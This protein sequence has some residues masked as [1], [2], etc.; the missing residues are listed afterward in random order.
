[1][2]SVRPE[3]EQHAD[4]LSRASGS[5]CVPGLMACFWTLVMLMCS[6]IVSAQPSNLDV[7]PLSSSKEAWLVTYGP[8]EIYWQ[9]FGH[10][11]IWIRDEENGIDHTFNFGFFDFEQERFIAR[12]IQGKMLYFAVAQVAEKEFEQ[13]QSENRSV[14]AQKLNLPDGAFEELRNY[15]VQQVQAE[16]RDY[17]YDYYLNNCSTRVRDALDMALGGVLQERTSGEA[18]SLNFR[19]H[20]RRSTV[21]DF[22]YYLAL[23]TALG[24]PVDRDI[25]RWEEMFLPELVSE[26]ISNLA[27]DGVAAA[28]PKLTIFQADTVQ[29]VD[30]VSSSWLR[31]LSV[32]ILITAFM[33]VLCRITGPIMSAGSVLAW[34]LIAASGGLVLTGL[35][36]FTDHAVASPNANILLLNPLF[37]I[38]LRQE[39][40]KFSA[41]LL[42]GGLLLAGL[43]GILSEGQ[44]NLDLLAFLAPVNVVCAWWLW[45][46][47]TT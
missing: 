37:L 42:F 30:D 13:Y 5:R 39:M 9:R 1:M 7:P 15:L 21:D 20:T 36:L 29:L 31:Y 25:S 26:V 33:V 43:Q 41:I 14:F 23:E 4:M 17:L 38:G 24:V 32:S 47:S 3:S 27:I 11:A 19:Q 40:R 18:A 35:W 28:D 2:F 44:Y 10:N 6:S 34:L 16:N 22:W 12:F 8:G 46:K 45:S